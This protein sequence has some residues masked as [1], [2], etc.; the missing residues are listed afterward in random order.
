MKEEIPMRRIPVRKRGPQD[1][2]PGGRDVGRIG[3]DGAEKQ[4]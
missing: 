2:R 1:L 4:N 3:K